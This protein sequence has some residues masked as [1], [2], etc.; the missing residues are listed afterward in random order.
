MAYYI[1]ADSAITQIP[2]LDEARRIA[3]QLFESRYKS[4]TTTR[5]GDS[6]IP[7]YKHGYGVTHSYVSR[8]RDGKNYTYYWTRRAWNRGTDTT[9]RIGKNG[10]LTGGY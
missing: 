4:N 10:K 9:Y 2:N 1:L 6:I 7:I 5:N 8:I 3:V